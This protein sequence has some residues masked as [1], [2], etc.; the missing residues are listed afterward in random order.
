M[1]LNGWHRLLIVIA[2]AWA[3]AVSGFA[4]LEYHGS[5]GELSDGLFTCGEPAQPPIPPTTRYRSRDCGL[6]P[7][8]WVAQGPFDDLPPY[9][10][11]LN[12]SRFLSILLGPGVLIGL[13]VG[14]ISWVAG[15]FR[16]EISRGSNSERN[17][18]RRAPLA[19]QSGALACSHAETWLHR[20]PQRWARNAAI[21]GGALGALSI[22]PP[23]SRGDG[24]F[25]MSMLVGIGLMTVCHAGAWYLCGLWARSS[26]KAPF[27]MGPASAAARITP[28]W[29]SGAMLL[30]ALVLVSDVLFGW[31]KTTPFESGISFRDWGY[32][33]R[34]FGTWILVAYLTALVSKRGLRK[35]ISADRQRKVEPDG[36]SISFCLPVGTAG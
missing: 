10:R 24:A 1:T 21:S 29:I 15:G 22:L 5:Q 6:F 7:R 27:L 36:P 2:A 31:R 33:T 13:C 28:N 25:V 32:L 23:L 9:R 17:T 12:F 18:L 35:A 30:G 16:Q 26:L 4:V 20:M 3:L 14:A 34:F 11:Y 8:T 19:D